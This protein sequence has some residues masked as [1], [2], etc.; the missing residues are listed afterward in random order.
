MLATF[1]LTPWHSKEFD[2]KVITYNV[3]IFNYYQENQSTKSV[4]KIISYLKK[5]DADVICLQ[6]FYNDKKSID[7]CTIRK[8]AE[9]YPHFY[10]SNSF[11]NRF[12]AQFGIVIFSKY[13]ILNHGE[14]DFTEKSKNIVSFIDIEKFKNKIRIYNLHL[15]SM[16]ID[17]ELLSESKI[18]KTSGKNIFYT[19]KKIKSG[20]KS[21]A[22]QIEAVLN[23][24]SKSNLKSIIA[25]DF[26][27]LPYTY[28]Y[29]KVAQNYKNAYVSSGF[30]FGFTFNGI[31]PFLRIDNQFYC[32]GIKSVKANV[33]KSVKNS[34]HF[35]LECWY[36]FD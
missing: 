8:I 10:F 4:E 24:A 9:K 16:H 19:I 18:N 28:T 12:G 3:K 2:L 29:Q 14:V 34:D 32:S 22:L 36:K 1:A 23:H 35:P 30:G 13:K 6:E 5:A 15:Q 33:N 17:T 7:F 31:I 25:G 27:D 26:N 20:M 11:R 21:R